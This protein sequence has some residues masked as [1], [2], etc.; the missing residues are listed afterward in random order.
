[1]HERIRVDAFKRARE[2][3]RVADLTPTSFSGRKAKNRSQP[4]AA[5]EKTVA[6]RLVKRRWFD[7]R[8][9]QIVVERP[10]NLL[11]A[12]PEI[13]FQ[14]HCDRDADCSGPR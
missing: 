13:R 12:G 1:M 2:G 14:I 5:G 10:V 7:V 11:S 3:K 9:R 4:F 8:L 6:H